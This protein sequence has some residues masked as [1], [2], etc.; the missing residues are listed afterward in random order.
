MGR[1]IGAFLAAIRVRNGA[2]PDGGRL[3]AIFPDSQDRPGQPL[4]LQNGP[5]SLANRGRGLPK[6]WLN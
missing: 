6:Y 1:K 5:F 3:S 4:G 2:P